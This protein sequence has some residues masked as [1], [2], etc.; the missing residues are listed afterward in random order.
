MHHLFAVPDSWCTHRGRALIAGGACSGLFIGAVCGWSSIS[1]VLLSDGVFAETESP[2][3]NLLV[4]YSAAVCAMSLSGTPAGLLCDRVP[5]VYGVA[6]AGTCIIAGALA[7]GALP[8]SAGFCFLPPF[9]LLAVGGNT[10][11]F[12][13]TKMA[14][15]FPARQ[16]PAILA[17]ICALYDASSAV[18]LLFFLAYNSGFSRDLIF[19]TYAALGAL[20]FGSWG[21]TVAGVG[22]GRGGGDSVDDDDSSGILQSVDDHAAL[23]SVDDDAARSPMLHRSPSFTSQTLSVASVVSSSKRAGNS[24][25]RGF[26]S[27][28]EEAAARRAAP[29]LGADGSSAPSNDAA[30]S[31]AEVMAAAARRGAVPPLHDAPLLRQLTSSQLVVGLAWY[32][33]SQ[34]RVNLYLGTARAMLLAQGDST[35]YYASLHTALLP[36]GLAFVPAVALAHARYGVVGTLQLNTL[37]G[38]CHG[39]CA[40]WLPLG[41]Q[42][43]TFCLFAC[44]RM[45]TFATFSIYTAEAFGPS[46]SAT[47][48]GFIFLVGGLASLLLVPIGFYVADALHGD[49]T[50]VYHAYTLLC[51]PQ[52][53]LLS[54]V[55]WH[56][57]RRQGA[58]WSPGG[59]GALRKA[60]GAPAVPSAS[61]TWSSISDDDDDSD[62]PYVELAAPLGPHCEPRSSR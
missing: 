1:V 55:S 50:L 2:N 5:L 15:L 51:L 35:G 38:A 11:F 54:L 37:V 41:W 6:A 24:P 13:T 48:T 34:Q 62:E 10:C 46:A 22:T 49:W 27:T 61:S 14:F 4:V 17:T 18:S 53:A 16:R 58:P 59:A 43:V 20:M 40:V 30:A 8:S 44:L 31:A 42:W 23:Q 45:A 28:A 12:A 25:P 52:L 9:V 33:L 3:E 36:A 57:Q 39:M 29:L 7:I 47:L 19:T 26:A 32:L 21:W 60:G 56:W